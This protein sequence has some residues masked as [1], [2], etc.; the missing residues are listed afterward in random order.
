M[1]LSNLTITLDGCIVWNAHNT[2]FDW[3][4]FAICAQA[5]Y[6]LHSTMLSVTCLRLSDVSVICRVTYFH[7]SIQFLFIPY[8]SPGSTAAYVVYP[9]SDIGRCRKFGKH[10]SCARRT[11]QGNNFELILTAKMETRHPVEGYFGSEFWAIC[12]L[13]GLLAAWS[14][15][16]LKF[17]EEFLR[18]FWKTTL[19]GIFQNSVPKDFTATPITLLCSFVRSF[20][21]GRGPANS[22]PQCWDLLN[23]SSATAQ[24]RGG[25]LIGV[26]GARA[27]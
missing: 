9:I 7:N 14:R 5:V 22:R 20:F 18:F 21:A 1:R 11:F 2:L 10:V 24:G 17:V 15:K 3:K 27:M 25:D 6:F 19:T 4:W 16:T 8:R 23:W 26:C 13:C 12:N